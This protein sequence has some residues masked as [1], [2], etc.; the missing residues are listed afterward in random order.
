MLNLC[1]AYSMSI[2]IEKHFTDNKKKR[3]DHYPRRL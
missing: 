1:T 2:V 3:N